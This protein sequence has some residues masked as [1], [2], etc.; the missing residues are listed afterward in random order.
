MNLKEK[1]KTSHRNVFLQ[2]VPWWSSIKKQMESLK[3]SFWRASSILSSISRQDRFWHHLLPFNTWLFISEYK[4]LSTSISCT[5][6]SFKYLVNE[7]YLTLGPGSVSSYSQI[8]RI[9]LKYKYFR[10]SW[11]NSSINSRLDSF[12]LVRKFF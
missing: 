6:I 4:C 3:I 7:E 1:L 12:N 10:S 8:C 5:N 9:S 11:V 2:Q